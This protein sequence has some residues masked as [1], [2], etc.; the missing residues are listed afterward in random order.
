MKKG[1]LIGDSHSAPTVSN[2]RYTWLGNYILEEKPDF[3]V[4]MGDWEDL[5][6]LCSYDKGTKSFEGRRLK[7]DIAAANDAGR[8]AF[9]PIDKYN[10]RRATNKKKQYKPDVIHLDGNHK[11]R[12]MKMIE[13]NPEFEGVF[14]YNDFDY[15][16]WA[17]GKSYPFLEVVT[18]E[19]IQFS[20]FF[21]NQMQSYSPKSIPAMLNLTRGSAAMGHNHLAGWDTKTWPNGKK[22]HGLFTGCFLD[23]DEHYD[24]F[25][26]AGPQ[27]KWWNGLVA[28]EEVYD[29]NFNPSFIGIETVRSK[30]A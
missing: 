25:N 20:H 10:A 18:Y 27:K 6:S 28:L 21:Y 4:N 12:M 17:G 26:Y 7:E 29:G 24:G 2:R 30:Y 11:Y 16:K 8:R 3:I 19:G 9:K 1:L 22:S 14:S 13:K 23:P 5:A 15:D